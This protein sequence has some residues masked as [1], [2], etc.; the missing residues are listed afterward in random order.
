MYDEVSIVPSAAAD[1][2]PDT[3][4]L[5]RAKEGLS[6]N[7]PVGFTLKEAKVM[8]GGSVWLRYTVDK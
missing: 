1:G 7:Q 5:F 8:D 3:P 6:K 4:P 2:S